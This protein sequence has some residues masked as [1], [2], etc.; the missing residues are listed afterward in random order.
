LFTT[1]AV[2]ETNLSG[3]IRTTIP[4]KA[5]SFF[6]LDIPVEDVPRFKA[7][8][9]PRRTSGRVGDDPSLRGAVVAIKNQRVSEMREI[10][11]GAWF[12]RGDRGLTYARQ[13]PE[14]SRVVSGRW[15]PA[16]Y[17]GPPL[18]SLDVEGA[19]AAGLAVGDRIVVAILGREIEATISSLREINWDTMGF[20]FVIVFSPG[21]L[22]TAAAQLHGDHLDAGS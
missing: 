17:S 10:P 6:M 3:Q 7:L 12:L 21:V 14:G 13:V 9:R 20:N 15:W 8:A 16:D 19:R 4:A 11:E 22:E 18:V 5:P 1:L 2:I